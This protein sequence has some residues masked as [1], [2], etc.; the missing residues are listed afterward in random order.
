MSGK[1]V[2]DMTEGMETNGKRKRGIQ[3][4]QP[5]TVNEKKKYEADKS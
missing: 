4:S 3:T 1:G 5:K 2:K